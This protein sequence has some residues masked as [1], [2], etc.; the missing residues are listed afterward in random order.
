MSDSILQVIR[1]H[2]GYRDTPYWDVNAYRIGYGSDTITTSD[3]R[4]V[5]VTQGMQVSRDDAERDLAR[6]VG[7]EFMP[8]AARAVGADRF[9]SL[10][11]QQQASLVSLA[12]NYG[13]GAWDDSLSGVAQ[14]VRSG[15][16]IAVQ[17]AIEGLAG[18]NGG[19]NRNRRMD[20]AS[21]FGMAGTSQ[22]SQQGDYSPQFIPVPDANALASPQ[23]TPEQAEQQRRLTAFEQ[24]QQTRQSNA[25][26]PADFVSQPQNALAVYGFGA[27]QSPYL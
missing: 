8:S 18:H 1:A 5:P 22:Q 25:L 21:A 17:R 2:E 13:A 20:E 7:S 26:N 16:M 11:P 14:A 4:V 12:Y 10:S 23:L 27:G 3:G 9:A 15:D 19:I 6:R 24:Y